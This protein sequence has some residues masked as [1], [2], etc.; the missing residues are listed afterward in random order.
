[1]EESDLDKIFINVYCRK[2]MGGIYMMDRFLNSCALLFCCLLIPLTVAKA[3]VTWEFI[4]SICKPATKFEYKG[5]RP[6][7]TVAEVKALSANDPTFFQQ[8]DA[9]DLVLSKHER[10]TW[11]TY[12]SHKANI[13]DQALYRLAYQYSF[14]LDRGWLKKNGTDV[15]NKI[16]STYGEPR[17]KIPPKV[18][19]K[20]FQVVYGPQKRT[21]NGDWMKFINACKA[22]IGGESA[23]LSKNAGYLLGLFLKYDEAYN[24][25]QSVCPKALDKEYHAYLKDHFQPTVQFQGAD[26]FSMSTNCPA[27]G[28]WARLQTLK[29]NK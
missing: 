28:K 8:N 13:P 26:N 16:L 22:E 14:K 23:V 1:M 12:D 6:G 5:I 17:S 29:K 2:Y 19:S 24:E 9:A 21:S 3:D 18:N 10:V 25:I 4:E 27:A 11:E 7:M 15:Y 20:F